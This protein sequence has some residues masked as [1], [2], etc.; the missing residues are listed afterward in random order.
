M[1][2]NS[3]YME[4]SSKEKAMQDSA[5]YQ[6]IVRMRLGLPIP[7]WLKREAKNLHACDERSVTGLCELLKSMTKSERDKLLY[8]DARDVQMRDIATWWEKHV[9]A[10]KARATRERNSAKREQVKKEALAKLTPAEKKAL[11]LK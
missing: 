10:D 1:P 9:K 2:C 6:I 11:G 8:S 5:R 7:A 4:P 3:D